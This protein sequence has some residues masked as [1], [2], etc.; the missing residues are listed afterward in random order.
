MYI[1]II[2]QK[3][4]LQAVLNEKALGDNDGVVGVFEKGMT[5]RANS[6]SKYTDTSARWWYGGTMIL[7]LLFGVIRRR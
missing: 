1:H 4:L 2:L 6:Y 5:S 7:T 3:E